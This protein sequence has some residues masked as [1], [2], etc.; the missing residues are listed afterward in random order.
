MKM[1]NAIKKLKL[2]AF[3]FVLFAAVGGFNLL[4]GINTAHAATTYKSDDGKWEFTDDGVIMKYLK[5]DESIVTIPEKLTANGVSYDIKK[6]DWYAIRDNKAITEINIGPNI[7]DV[8]L[9]PFANLKSLQKI[10]VSPENEYYCDVN[11][12][13]YNK[14]KKV[15]IKYPMNSPN[16]VL[17]LPD[18]FLYCA[19][20]SSIEKAEKVELLRISAK[21]Y[22][23]PLSN[24]VLLEP[25]KFPNLK[26]IVVS[27]ENT[28]LTAEEGVLY[29]HDMTTLYW[30]PPKKESSSFTIPDSVKT[31]E[32]KAFSN[33]IYLENLNLTPYIE[34]IKCSF[35]G[36]N[37]TSINN[38]KTREEYINWD[39]AIKSVFQKH[40][41]VLENLPFS[42][43]LVEQE[44]EYAVD[45][46]IKEGMKDC[47]KV[48][49]LYTYATNKVSYTT[50]AT[51]DSKNHCISSVFLGDETVCE[52]YALAMSLLLDR[53]G[54]P[55]CCVVG[56]NHAWNL[57][58]VN[59]VW[60]Q[61]DAT[62]DDNDVKDRPGKL[63]FLKSISEYEKTGHPLYKSNIDKEFTKYSFGVDKSIYNNNLPECNIIIGDINKDG[64][65]DDMD[66]HHM[67]NEIQGYAK[68]SYLGYY[69]I[70]ADVN[71]DGKIDMDDYDCLC[72]KIMILN[73]NGLTGDLNHNGIHD[74][75]DLVLLR[76]EIE[77]FNSQPGYYNILADLDNNRVIDE[78]DYM[79]LEICVEL[80][81]YQ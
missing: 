68:Y 60:L 3:V 72:E 49:A 8:G 81:K 55:N 32:S 65:L 10:N 14:Q 24:G 79:L 76:Y 78:V 17:N 42:I 25:E 45:S 80:Q 61:I 59:G 41:A 46:Y 56:G 1:K 7:V 74:E 62:W 33:A 38:I 48:Y 67:I 4:F 28:K 2:A 11:G 26:L 19:S 20:V 39:P 21:Y 22:I 64:V 18:S 29:S 43:S 51:S 15:L 34:K 36:C 13:L 50:G 35:D 66:K 47:E 44:V 53:V 23:Y 70:L 31:I 30:Y 5:N 27:P 75:E 69:N 37:I 16:K 77:K 52:G 71:F 12:V 63:Y 54:I 6:V 40:I 73:K 57:V 58:Q 9:S